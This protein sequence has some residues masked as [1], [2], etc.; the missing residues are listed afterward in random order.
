MLGTDGRDYEGT[1]AEAG[2]LTD[3]YKGKHDTI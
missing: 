2:M 1:V 3:Y